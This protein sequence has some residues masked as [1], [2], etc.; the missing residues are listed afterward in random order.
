[1][2]DISAYN[3]SEILELENRIKQKK[4]ALQNM[5]NL[6]MTVFPSSENDFINH[7]LVEVLMSCGRVLID[8]EERKGGTDA[9]KSD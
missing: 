9:G 7:R 8:L 1:M 4:F 6:F 3:N 5:L 2:I